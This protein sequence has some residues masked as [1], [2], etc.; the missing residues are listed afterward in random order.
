MSDYSPLGLMERF[1]TKNVQIL[2]TKS[3]L[4]LLQDHPI[5]ANYSTF[6]SD[7]F[8]QIIH[9]EIN[10][11]VRGEGLNT[12]ISA[13]MFSRTSTSRLLVSPLS[14]KCCGLTMPASSYKLYSYMTPLRQ[15]MGNF[16]P[17]HLAQ[18]ESY[19]KCTSAVEMVLDF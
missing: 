7:L 5:K 13:S 6:S 8:F 12:R 3:L 9:K 11:L 15:V 18:M 19:A 16:I 1:W 2:K 17:I 4:S 10:R 14:Q